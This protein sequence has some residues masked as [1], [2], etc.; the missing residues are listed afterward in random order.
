MIK[1]ASLL[2]VGDV[3]NVEPI[4]LR[5]RTEIDNHFSEIKED[6]SGR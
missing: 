4:I 6:E 3:I 1:V 2:Y 5:R